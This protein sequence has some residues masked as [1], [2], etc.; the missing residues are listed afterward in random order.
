M[1]E[2]L[3]SCPF[4]GSAPALEDYRTAWAVRC[5]CGA[6]VLGERAPEPDSDMGDA[7][8]A[9]YEASAI[10]AWNRRAQRDDYDSLQQRC[11]NLETVQRAGLER[12]GR[13]K[14]AAGALGWT[15][16]HEDGP[17]DFIIRK[18]TRC[19]ELEQHMGASLNILVRE[20]DALRAELNARPT[21]EAYD[22]ACS[23]LW[24]HRDDETALRAEVEAL[25]KDAERYRAIRYSLSGLP[26]CSHTAMPAISVPMCYGLTY[27]PD[28]LDDA[29]DHAME[30][31]QCARTT[32][33]TPEV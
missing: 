5:Q 24:K 9:R 28:G 1:S 33:S 30:A 26:G 32:G 11:S 19:L 20:R 25:R 15:A 23:A 10:T 18:A 22:A 13:I 2:E 8:W 4:C 21:T 6:C 17:L 16:V 27:T 31:S 7:Y 29:V 14:A 3:K 12:S